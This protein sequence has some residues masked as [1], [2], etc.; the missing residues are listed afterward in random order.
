MMW[1]LPPA[2]PPAH[3]TE[4]GAALY[5]AMSSATDLMGEWVGTTTIVYSPV[6]R[7]SGVTSASVT[8]DLLVAN[9]ATMP[10]PPTTMASLLPA[11]L[12]MNWASPMAPPAPPT[13]TTVTFL[14][15]P[16]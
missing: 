10:K 11:L 5:F 16:S 14:P 13:L 6:S 9:E 7:A 15:R 2:E 8:G 4:R 1:S 12:R 3:D